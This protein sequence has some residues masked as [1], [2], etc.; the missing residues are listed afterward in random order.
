[1]AKGIELLY[2][3]NVSS[4]AHYEIFNNIAH[5]F[6]LEQ[7]LVRWKKDL[8][9]RILLFE[10]QDLYDLRLGDLPA[11]QRSRVVLTLRYHNIRILIHRLLLVH[12]LELAGKDDLDEQQPAMFEYQVYPGVY[13]GG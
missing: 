8:P 6:S 5:L 2:G 11:W 1:M 10:A 13:H 3:R 4:N 9:P 7:Q 12:F